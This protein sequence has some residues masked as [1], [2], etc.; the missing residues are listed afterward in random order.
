MSACAVQNDFSFRESIDQ[1]PVWCDVAFP[2]ILPFTLEFMRPTALW[3][4]F[5]GN[6]QIYDGLE[7]GPIA[8]APLG[9]SRIFL[10]SVAELEDFH[11]AQRRD[12]GQTSLIIEST[13][14]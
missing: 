9:N 11:K 7:F 13:L 12:T 2:M 4:R 3:K 14:S 5:I 1:Q 10:K 8:A 6:E